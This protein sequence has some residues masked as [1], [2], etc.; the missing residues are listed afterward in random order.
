MLKKSGWKKVGVILVLL[1][2]RVLVL[3]EMW[4]D[5]VSGMCDLLTIYSNYKSRLLSADELKWKNEISIH[6][7]SEYCGGR[8]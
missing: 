3:N 5:W 6:R 4:V 1:V 7:W 2:Y 8:K